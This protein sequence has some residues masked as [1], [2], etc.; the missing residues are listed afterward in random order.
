MNADQNFESLGSVTRNS[1][2]SPWRN[3][4]RTYVTALPE[5]ESSERNSPSIT[6][7]SATEA[8]PWFWAAT[9][10]VAGLP[11]RKTNCVSSRLSA[12]LSERGT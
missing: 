4:R 8:I 12:P 6:C 5:P 11:E 10:S 9:L 3:R 2:S 7:A 1:R